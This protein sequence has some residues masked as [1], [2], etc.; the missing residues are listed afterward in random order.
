MRSTWLQKRKGRTDCTRSP[1]KLCCQEKA[2]NCFWPL[3][4]LPSYL[5]FLQQMIFPVSRD[6]L[7]NKGRVKLICMA[8][9]L[10]QTRNLMCDS[11]AISEGRNSSA[12]HLWKVEPFNVGRGM[13]QHAVAMSA[14]N[15]L[16][17]HMH[18]GINIAYEREI[19]LVHGLK[20]S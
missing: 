16:W 5:Y 13:P 17:T 3:I 19:K 15:S 11:S 6:T 20:T 18:K 8:I 10:S 2:A 12:M 1:E 7:L 14:E 9:F 4:P